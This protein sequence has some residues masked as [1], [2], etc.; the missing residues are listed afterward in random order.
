MPILPRDS[1]T[2]RSLL[3]V[4]AIMCFLA[5][6]TVG[7]VRIARI[8][9]EAWRADLSRE[10]TIQVRPMEGR[11]IEADVKKAL[12]AAQAT[13]GIVEARAYTKEESEKLLEPWLGARFDLSSLPVPRLIRLRVAGDSPINLDSL[14]LA[15]LASVPGAVVDDHR[16]FSARLSTISNTVTL[17][18]LAILALVLAATVLSVS[19]ATRG[20][21]AANRP[22]VEVLHF[23][24]ARDSFVAGIFQRHFLEAGLKGALIGG[25]GAALL[26]ALWRFAA[27]LFGFFA[28]EGDAAFLTGSL[29]LDLMGYLEIAA[30]I[31]F[32]VFVV[33]VSSRFTVYATLRNID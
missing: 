21:V 23:V 2:S 5:A 30:A 29:N 6:L 16:A 27:R 15:L 4:V 8:S 24:G 19:F 25:I 14:R 31:I 17:G 9:T 32:V 7:A 18:G 1:V 13:S 11:D 22:T 12:E 20:A 33:A 10:M 3:A 26:F 28:G